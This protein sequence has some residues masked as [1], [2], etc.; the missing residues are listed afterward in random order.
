MDI[1]QLYRDFWDY[2]FN[3]PDK[4]KPNDIAIYSFAIEHCNRLGW[5]KKFGFP[6]TMAM[7]ATG[8]KSYSVY[9]KH[10]DNLIDC[11]FFEI[12]EFSKNQYSSN[13]IALKENYKAND[14][15]QYKALDKALIKH[16]TKQSEST[17]QS[18][19]SITKQLNNRTN[20]QLNNRTNEQL[21]N[22]IKEIKEKE[23][24]DLEIENKKPT[25]K[26]SNVEVLSKYHDELETVLQIFNEVLKTDY[27]SYKSFS[28]NYEYWRKTYT[29]EEI[30]QAIRNIPSDSFW[31]DRIDPTVFFR[32][33][34]QNGENADYI[35][36]FRN[37]R[38]KTNIE[39]HSDNV[40]KASVGYIQKL[41]T[42]QA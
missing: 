3:N 12:I 9:K 33:K 27:R 18:I 17:V 34:Y 29:P 32:R 5:K 40:E 6:T 15:A 20:E 21:N 8:I 10:F 11:G 23:V 37:Q 1:F 26:K 13:I 31:N 22:E 35:G 19:D 36:K 4:I 2:T 28:A 42:Q 39:K 38:E 30:E 14:K 16:G 25:S 7:E 24:F 41:M